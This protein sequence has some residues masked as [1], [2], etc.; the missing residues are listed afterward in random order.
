MKIKT[1]LVLI[2]NIKKIKKLLNLNNN[3][4]VIKLITVPINLIAYILNEDNFSKFLCMI[5]HNISL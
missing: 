2:I 3:N 4:L 5:H 1:P